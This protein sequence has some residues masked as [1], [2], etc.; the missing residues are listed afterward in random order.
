MFNVGTAM[1]WPRPYG[2]VVGGFTLVEEYEDEM[3]FLNNME[4][5]R[6]RILSW[7]CIETPVLPV[8]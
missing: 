8:W 2:C 5:T 4:H 7:C 3:V 6:S 1:V